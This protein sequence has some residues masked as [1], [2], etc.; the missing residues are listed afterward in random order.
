MIRVMNEEIG[1][2]VALGTFVGRGEPQGT[3]GVMLALV[4]GYR[5]P[6]QL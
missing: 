2:E 4:V 6:R 1:R 5:R 3:A